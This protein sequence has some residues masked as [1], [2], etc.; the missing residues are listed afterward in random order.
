MAM[1]ADIRKMYN[2][3]Y[4][5][6]LEQHCHRFLWRNLETDRDPDIYTILRVNMG[7]KPA[8]AISSEAIYKTADM[9][10]EKYPRV[11]DLLK[12]ATYV[13]DI[14]DSVDNGESA[15]Q[16]ARDTND[17]LNSAGFKIKHW[18]LSGDNGVR[19]SVD[20]S[21]D[22]EDSGV[23]ETKVLGVVWKPSTDVIAFHPSL[24]FSAKKRGVYLEGDLEKHQ[25]PDSIPMILTRR[26]VLEQVMK[27]YDPF[28]ILS[29]FTLLAK[30]LLRK[31]WTLNLGWDDALPD[32]MWD[33]WSRFFTQLFQ[34]SELEFD[35]VL[36]PSNRVG[37]PTLVVMSD[38]SDLAYG[39]VAYIRWELNDG[40]FWSRLVLA[41]C[42]I[43]PLRK[44]STPQMELNGAVLSKRCRK[45]VE[46]ELRVSFD[47]VYQLVD[48]ATV[49]NMLNKVST[50]FKIYE[51]VRIGEIQ[52]ATEGDMSDWHWI[53]GSSNTSDWVTRGR[54]PHEL[55]PDSEWWCGPSFMRLPVAEWG[56]KGP[57]RTDEVLPG[58][59]QVKHA[60]VN[61]ATL[62]ETSAIYDIQ[63]FSSA[64]K[65]V[66]KVAKIMNVGLEKSFKGYLSSNVTASVIQKALEYLVSREQ[67]TMQEELQRKRG[68]YSHLA[69]VVDEKG[70][71]VV[72]LRMSRYN[73]MTNPLTDRP[74]ILLPCDSRLTYLLMRD[75]HVDCGHRGRDSTLA[76]FHQKFW[77]TRGN[78]LA[79]KVV[80]GCF[81]CKRKFPKPLSQQMGKLPV[82]RLKPA[83]PFTHV[84]VDLFG[85]YVIRG[86][87]QKRVSGKGYG[88]IFT[89][90]CS[91]AVHIEGSFGY[92]T[93]SF[94]MALSRFAHVRGWP[95]R[96]YSDCGTQIV[97][98]SNAL[99]TVWNS[100]DHDLIK[101]RGFSHGT[102]WIFG[103]PDAPWHQGAV[104]S[105]VKSAK[106]AIPFA[107]LPRSF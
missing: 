13:D 67:S 89:D 59:K 17:V 97:A 99:Q 73:P 80:G 62:N 20:D 74:Q 84:M 56:M 91:R 50:R 1:A 23:Y 30:I 47:D 4:I 29:P 94:L 8:G 21:P 16:L 35:R 37:K 25:V 33:E 60:Q 71:W 28:G 19:V 68:R 2:S 9:H 52:Q 44:L 92:D 61:L 79:S 15:M 104:E 18:I 100:L 27:L 45:V 36:A 98:A 5:E 53:C 42:R 54:V 72:G 41:K 106:R 7:D 82:D 105:L 40:S 12:S 86:E 51:G 49:L 34:C 83:P 81:M 39:C 55:G 77:T 10:K 96:V 58:E 66:M 24:N 85:P 65:L 31:T 48:S 88:V 6:E 3:I 26:V 107:Y 11:A 32:I 87:V 95:E 14:L 75:A 22:T 101:Q 70:L 90:L 43:A 46:S 64:S 102:H 69:P 78:A 63:D 38:G 93:Q 103:A 57:E 76:R